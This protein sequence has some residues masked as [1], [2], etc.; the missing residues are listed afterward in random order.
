[1]LVPFQAE[2]LDSKRFQR[3]EVRFNLLHTI[4]GGE[5]AVGL[6]AEDGGAI[7]LASPGRSMWLWVEE[8][9][10]DAFAAAV[11]TELAEQLKDSR[12]P[13]ISSTP[14]HAKLFLEQYC[15]RSGARAGNRMRLM[16]YACPVVNTPTG[17][18]GEWRQAQESHAETVADFLCGFNMDCFHAETNREDALAGANGMISSGHLLVWETNGKTVCMGGAFRRFPRQAKLGPVYTPPEERNKGYAAALVAAISQQVLGEGLTPILYADADYP[19]SNKA[20][21]NVGYLA[22]GLVEEIGFVY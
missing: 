15:P 4:A 2:S 8:S 6:Q 14:E 9:K 19:A 20:Y 18:S 7:A 10:G 12:L 16:A 3:D 21:Q 1:M 13:G 17:V 11:I 22:A 5:L